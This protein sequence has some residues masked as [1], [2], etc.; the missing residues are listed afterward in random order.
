MALQFGHRLLHTVADRQGVRTRALKYRDDAAGLAV[1]SRPLLVVESAEFDSGD[2]LQSDNRAVRIRADDD[3]PEFLWI[4][5]TALRANCVGHLL[6]VGRGLGAH[7]PG[8]VH[9]ALR[10]NRAGKVGNSQT[11]FGEQIRLD[12]DP[13]GVIARSEKPHLAHARNTVEHIVDVDV[14]VVSEEE[15]VISFVGREER[16]D[17]RRKSGRLAQS[18]TKLVDIAWKVRLSLREPILDV[19]L[20]AIDVRVHVER[21]GQTLGAVV[22]ISGLH[23]E[24]V[25]YTVHLLLERRG[26]RLLDCDRICSGVGR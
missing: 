15:R 26:D 1:H 16:D 7:L 20:I 6:P 18:D 22:R 19:Y 10:L 4:L 2:V 14:C 13:H 9:G 5:E 8:R 24:H 21:Y 3:L 17:E 11:K 25:V 23:V 12:P